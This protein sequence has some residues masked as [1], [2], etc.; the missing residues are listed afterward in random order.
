MIPIGALVKAS[1]RSSVTPRPALLPRCL[2]LTAIETS[3]L[4]RQPKTGATVRDE[5]TVLSQGKKGRL[6][7][8]AAGGRTGARW[9]QKTLR[10]LGVRLPGL[11]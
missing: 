10:A 2:T 1:V 11:L 8:Q 4:A 7:R 5:L 6:A 3:L 9:R